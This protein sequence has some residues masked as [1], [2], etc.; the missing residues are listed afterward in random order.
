[1]NLLTMQL[2]CTLYVHVSMYSGVNEDKTLL[3]TMHDSI[4]VHMSGH[5]NMLV[6]INILK[7]SISGLSK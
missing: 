1:M 6:Y 4:C 7:S 2:L 5:A 3:L